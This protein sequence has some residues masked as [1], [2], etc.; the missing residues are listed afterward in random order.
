MSSA[1][2]AMAD[3]GEDPG[4]QVG[5]GAA[6]AGVAA[7]GRHLVAPLELGCAVSGGPL[8]RG[9][10]VG[11]RRRGSRRSGPSADA[12][13]E[14][15]PAGS[16]LLARTRCRRR[17]R[18]RRSD[19]RRPTSSRPSAARRRRS[20]PRPSRR[21]RRGSAASARWPTPTSRRR[22]PRRRS[23]LGA[24]RRRAGSRPV[25]GSVQCGSGIGPLPS[26]SPA[27]ARRARL[28][29][30]EPSSTTVVGPV[31]LES[32]GEPRAGSSS[33]RAARTVRRSR[34][35]AE[36]RL[37]RP[38]LGLVPAGCEP[39]LVS[40]QNSSSSARGSGATAPLGRPESS[41]ARWPRRR[42]RP[43]VA[44]RLCRRSSGSRRRARIASQPSSRRRRGRTEAASRPGA[45]VLLEEV[46]SI[47]SCRSNAR[48]RRRNPTRSLPVRPPR[49]DRA[50]ED[51]ERPRADTR[52]DAA[53]GRCGRRGPGRLDLEQLL[54]LVREQACRSRRRPR[55]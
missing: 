19:A 26:A 27:A 18:A 22:R 52:A 12:S 30:V 37:A 21:R 16:D 17:R 7:R 53:I 13:P 42:R 34:H 49:L 6:G 48:A 8:R 51:S 47:R 2:T 25:G 14:A 5:A 36:V 1:T 41:S 45:V 4:L 39:R 32:L 20:R 33:R 24:R 3:A 31:G 35:S 29:A 55:A 9:A 44:D 50:V 43:L 28:E 23:S 38:V 10:P 54:L 11:R 40:P 46:E 15:A